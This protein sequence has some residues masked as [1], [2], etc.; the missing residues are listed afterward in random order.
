MA[1]RIPVESFSRVVGYLKPKQQYN[2]GK[3]EEFKQRK[4]YDISD[5]EKLG[6]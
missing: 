5:I 1:Q 2:L 6:E 4:Y 3:S